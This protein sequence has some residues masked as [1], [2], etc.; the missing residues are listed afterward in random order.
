L[1]IDRYLRRTVVRPFAATLGVLVALFAGFSLAGILADAV[2]GLLPVGVIVAL[3]GLKVLIA[4]DVLIPISLFIAV[5]V[6]FGR[7]QEDSELTSMQALG[8]SPPRL[9]RPVLVLAVLLAASV[10]CLSLF[11]RPW[12]YAASHIITNRASAMLNLNAMEAGIFYASR[13]GD[14]VIFLGGRAGPHGPAQRVFVAR[15]TDGHVVVINAS[16]AQPAVTNANGQRR[17]YLSDAHIYQLDPQN[18][19]NDRVV[20]AAGVSLNPDGALP[21]APGY[22][23]V[24]ARSLRLAASDR[25]ADIAEL[26]WRLSTGL[27]TLLLAL[28]G[29]TLSRGRPR[30]NRYA[31]FGPAILA[32][33]AYYL[34]C[35]VARTWVEHGRVESFPGLWWAPAALALALLAMWWAP[36]LPL[37]RISWPFR[38][39]PLTR[40]AEMAAA[41]DR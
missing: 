35:T 14:Q 21:G 40:A 3:A 20:D 18:P 38:F 32:Y 13:D 27:S 6:A 9:A 15:K 29:M 8:M 19:A 2:G 11:A 12:A 24:A 5:V 16:G 7:L 25:P 36:S 34:L 41:R 23:P 31:K 28:L 4:L 1:T 33:S 26:Q 17:V 39:R 30:Q 10:S 22:S 37:R